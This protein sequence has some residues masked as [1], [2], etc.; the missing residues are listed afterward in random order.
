MNWQSDYYSKFKSAEEAVKIVKSGDTVVYGEFVMASRLLD[1]ALAKRVN[2]FENVLLRSTTCPFPPAVV[3]A[4]PKMEHV[5]YN[6]WHF[7]PASRKLG[8]HGLCR[9]IPM[10]YHEG[11]NTIRRGLVGSID[12]AMLM[13]GPPDEDG[14]LNIGTSSSITPEYLKFAKHVIVEIN[15][16][17]PKCYSDEQSRVHVSRVD[18]FVQGPNGPMIEVPTAPPTEVDAKIAELVVSLID[19][20][21]CIQLGI[22]AMPNAVGQLI[23]QSGLKDLGVHTEMLC[24]AYVSMV[25]GGCISGKYKT[26]DPGKIVYTFATGTNRLYNFLDGNKDCMIAPVDYT[27]DPFIIA[28]NDKMV[29]LNN[30]LEVDLFGQVAS[31]TSGIRQISGTGGQLDFMIAATHSKGGKGLMCLS[32]TFTDKDGKVHSRI[33]PYIDPC[34][35]VTVPRSY[36]QYVITEYG[37]ADL[38]AKTS[39]ERAEALIGIAHPDFR[40]ELTQAAQAEH[41]W[42]WREKKIF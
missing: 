31:E 20:G 24:D 33:R 30:A 8:D 37:I 11:P 10:N 7:S 27:N 17:I 1:E 41:I 40:E 21:S 12:V 13:M 6:D 16:S 5:M 28:Q 35:I 34:T 38:R 14:Y 9:Y 2:E 36:C 29:C 32:S 39:W 23:G 15:E 42:D 3:M 4:D 18:T 26:T 19:N 22:G 25:E